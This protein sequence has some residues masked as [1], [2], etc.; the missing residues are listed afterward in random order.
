MYEV[1]PPSLLE[2]AHIIYI[3]GTTTNLSLLGSAGWAV[4]NL[5][6]QPA[7]YLIPAAQAWLSRNKFVLTCARDGITRWIR[8]GFGDIDRFVRSV[9]AFPATYYYAHVY[10]YMYVHT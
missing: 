3:N 7:A 6:E 1:F 10:T 8:D 5:I 2:L 4:P 9:V